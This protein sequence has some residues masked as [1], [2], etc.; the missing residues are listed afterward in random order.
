M[1][2]DVERVESD[3]HT[4]TGPEDPA[5]DALAPTERSASYREDESPFRSPG[6]GSILHRLSP[7]SEQL[8]GYHPKTFRRDV[9]AGITVAA[10]A[11]PSGIAYAGLAGVS[12]VAGLYALLLPTLVYAFLG[13]SRQLIVGPEGSITALI[14]AAILPLAASDPTRYASMAALLALLVGGIYLVA[15]II[16]LGWVADYFSR[17]VLTGYIHGVAIFLIIAQLGKLF[18]LD[19]AAQ[20]PLPQL[21]EFA[22]S[23]G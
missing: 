17:P 8:P 11:I 4:T 3:P 22:R 10:I 18:G 2:H 16:R 1:A 12:P 21:A 9:M 13:S 23:R 5:S 14:A 20:D 19:I 6:R 7:L 15:R